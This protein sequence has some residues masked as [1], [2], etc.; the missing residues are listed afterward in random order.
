MQVKIPDTIHGFYGIL[1]PI[2]ILSSP[3]TT[4]RLLTAQAVKNR[5]HATS[6]CDRCGRTL[7][8]F[9]WENRLLSKQKG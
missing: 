3:N 1:P 4:W 7:S 8:G 6:T 2:T 9:T 5:R